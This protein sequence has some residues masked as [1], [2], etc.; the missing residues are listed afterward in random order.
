MMPM[1]M[2]KKFVLSLNCESENERRGSNK[3]N[4]NE[5]FSF[6]TELRVVNCLT[7]F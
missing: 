3:K 5:F 2:I 7:E 6:F 4:F 1:N